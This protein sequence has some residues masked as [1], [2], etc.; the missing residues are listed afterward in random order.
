[1]IYR[2]KLIWVNFE[3][4]L[5]LVRFGVETGLGK[6]HS[7]FG[8]N[9]LF[10]YFRFPLAWPNKLAP[11]NHF[12]T[13]PRSAKLPPM[14]HHSPGE[15]SPRPHSPSAPRSRAARA[16]LVYLGRRKGTRVWVSP[17]GQRAG[18]IGLPW[19]TRCHL[20]HPVGALGCASCI[21]I[22][23]HRRAQDK[24]PAK[25]RK[26]GTQTEQV[27]DVA[28]RRHCLLG[29]APAFAGVTGWG[30]GDGMGVE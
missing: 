1:M 26:A 8:H 28:L 3:H 7:G 4:P 22:P 30:W 15:P 20:C 21:V 17:W 6:R 12:P 27:N 23:A 16:A 9:T 5:E 18:L 13:R 2:P 24:L 19:V 11:P 25:G 10:A 14:P 29:W